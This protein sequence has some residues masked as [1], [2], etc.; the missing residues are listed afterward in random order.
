[1]L[2]SLDAVGRLPSSKSKASLLS[3]EEKTLTNRLD[4]LVEYVIIGGRGKKQATEQ[5]LDRAQNLSTQLLDLR[6]GMFWAGSRCQF[7]E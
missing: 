6:V 7:S 1:M 4:R 2:R 5:E 3:V